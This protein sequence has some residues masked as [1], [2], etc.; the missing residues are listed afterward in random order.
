MA[1]V[2][3][4]LALSLIFSFKSILN[5]FSFL[6]STYIFYLL[7]VSCAFVVIVCLYAVR[8]C[9]IVFS[10]TSWGFVEPINDFF[11]VCV[12]NNL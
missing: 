11:C 3:L 2:R 9:W 10:F 7:T 5:F 8:V 4:L 6:F 12:L 1:M